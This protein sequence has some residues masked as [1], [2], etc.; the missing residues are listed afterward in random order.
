MENNKQ[1]R[2]QNKTA[3]QEAWLARKSGHV[4]LHLYCRL[5][6][7]Q[8][9]AA[10]AVQTTNNDYSNLQG[11]LAQHAQCR[12]PVMCSQALPAMG[13]T[14]MP[15][16][17]W[18]SPVLAL[19]SSIELHRNLQGS[20]TAPPT[21]AP[22]CGRMPTCDGYTVQRVVQYLSLGQ[23]SSTASLQHGAYTRAHARAA[24]TMQ[25]S[26]QYKPGLWPTTHPQLLL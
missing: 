4:E 12:V 6:C 16:K 18:L 22:A 7:M 1:Q 9:L 10:T 8:A 26:V 21:A 23:A 24:Y 11:V 25:P 2:S 3:C 20:R 5:A 17:A 19:N 15:R 14:I 13:S